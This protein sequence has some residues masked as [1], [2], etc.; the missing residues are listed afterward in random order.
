M[1]PA[2]SIVV[3]RLRAIPHNDL[4]NSKD[5]LGEYSQNSGA[6]RGLMVAFDSMFLTF[7]FVPTHRVKPTA[8]KSASTI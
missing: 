8:L 6:D 2:C 7:L 4:M 5:P 1:T 3:G